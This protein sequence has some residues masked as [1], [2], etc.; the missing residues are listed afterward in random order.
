MQFRMI[1]LSVCYLNKEKLRCKDYNFNIF[2]R[3]KRKEV[4]LFKYLASSHTIF[5]CRTRFCRPG[6]CNFFH[7]IK[8]LFIFMDLHSVIFRRCLEFW[9]FLQPRLCR[10][11]NHINVPGVKELKYRLTECQYGFITL[12]L[13]SIFIAYFLVGLVQRRSYEGFLTS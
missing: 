5:R 7:A 11:V 4:N 13:I 8:H 10:Q 3:W 12:N 1:C 9:S 2:D 6:S